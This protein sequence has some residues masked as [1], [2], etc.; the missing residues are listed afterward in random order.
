MGQHK[1]QFGQEH[2]N[3]LSKHERS[4]LF[5]F[6]LDGVEN[7]CHLV[8]VQDSNIRVHM[9][10]EC[11]VSDYRTMN[12]FLVVFVFCMINNYIMNDRIPEPKG[13]SNGRQ[14]KREHIGKYFKR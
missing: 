6:V 11:I 8:F 7:I 3:K 9:E 13:E 1:A 14:Y 5:V 12:V 10:R 2:A 4:V